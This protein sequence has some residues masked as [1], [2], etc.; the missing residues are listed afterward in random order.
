MTD[1][2][3]IKAMFDDSNTKYEIERGDDY[4]DIWVEN[5]GAYSL[6]SFNLDEKFQYIEVKSKV[7]SE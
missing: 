4:I 6:F 7:Y 5:D 1:F 3:S 2:E